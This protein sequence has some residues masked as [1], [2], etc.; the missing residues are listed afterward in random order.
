M[1][2]F[3]GPATLRLSPANFVSSRQAANLN[4]SESSRASDRKDSIRHPGERPL[5]LRN[6]DQANVADGV[7]GGGPIAPALGPVY[8][9]VRP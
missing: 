2:T 7:K 3:I 8:P 9:Q 4:R 5:H 1:K 6:F